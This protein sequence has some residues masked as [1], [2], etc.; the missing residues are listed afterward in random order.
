ML[1]FYFIYHLCIFVLIINMKYEGVMKKI[2]VLLFTLLA[3]N[4][5]AFDV[6]RVKKISCEKPVTKTEN[7]NTITTWNCTFAEGTP[8]A[9]AYKEII[10][11]LSADIEKKILMPKSKTQFKQNVQNAINKKNSKHKI[12]QI[13][14]KGMIYLEPT[15]KDSKNAE[16]ST[17]IGV[18]DENHSFTLV[19]EDKLKL[20]YVITKGESQIEKTQSYEN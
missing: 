20:T 13:G 12:S 17:N 15:Y 2:F 7:N 9:Y 1:R 4:A 6:E 3:F 14:I 11:D 10:N 19:Q 8:L 16:I 5:F 18:E